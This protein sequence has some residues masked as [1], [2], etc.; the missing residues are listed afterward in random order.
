MKTTPIFKT[1]FM[2]SIFVMVLSCDNNQKPA[3]TKD[4]AQEENKEKFDTMDQENDAKFLVKAAEINVEEIELGK[5]AQESA[6]KK[7]IKDLGKMM[8]TAHQKAQAEL[9]T[10]ASRKNISIP[11]GP[12]DKAKEAY[13]KLTSKSGKDFDKEYSNM[14]VMGH[15]DAIN[16]FEKASKNSKDPDISAFAEKMLPELNMHLEHSLKAKEMC[17]KM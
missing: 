15:K 13:K 6:T 5:L 17:E 1:F 16:L 9:S 4:L 14:M 10:L 7:E 2:L 12:T 8:E 11:A 3:D